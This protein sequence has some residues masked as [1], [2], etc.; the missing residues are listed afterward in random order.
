MTNL[1]DIAI[2]APGW[3]RCMRHVTSDCQTDAKTRIKLTIK[4]QQLHT[5]TLRV[6]SRRVLW[7]R[8]D[9]DSSLSQPDA[10]AELLSKAH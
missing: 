3:W 8:C 9:A 6:C 5:H 7:N 4:N 1:N 10:Y 2:K